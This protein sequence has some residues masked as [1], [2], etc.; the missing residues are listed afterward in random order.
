MDNGSSKV[1]KAFRSQH[2]D[3][4]GPGK[5]GIRFHPKENIDTIRAQA[6]WMTWKCA[7]ANLPLGGSMGGFIADPRKLSLREQEMICRGWIRQLIKIIGPLIDIPY[8]DLMTNSQHTVWMLDEYETLTGVK[9]PGLITGKPVS[10][11]GSRGREEA[12]GYGVIIVVREALRARGINIHNTSASVQGFGSVGQY[13][14]Q[15]FQQMGG[16]ISCVSCLDSD[17]QK[18]IA[19]VRDSG[20]DYEELRSITNSYGEIDKNKAQ[21]LGYGLLPGNEWLTQDVDILIPAA[22]G[23]QISRSSVVSINSSV[24][25]I[26]E[27]ANGP[28][29]PRAEKLLNSREIQIIPDLIT[30]AGGVICSY[31]EQVQGNRNFF[32]GKNDI[33]GLLDVKMTSAFRDISKFGKEH[34][35]I[36]R[37]A[38]IVMAVDRVAK[39]C[40][41]RGWV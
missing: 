36:L 28:T 7:V 19:F 6:M 5:G 1:F 37:D 31:Y 24:I 16:R 23:Q 15:L 34:G 18:P 2:N 11:G 26:A 21:D 13:V 25:M 41:D 29:T 3:A 9:A 39:A 17:T 33:L 20:V 32:W 14:V 38:A 30:N 27:G 35:L 22:M 40:R 4:R 8:P 10:L 12:I